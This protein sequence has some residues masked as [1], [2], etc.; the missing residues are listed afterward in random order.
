MGKMAKIEVYILLIGLILF[1]VGVVLGLDNILTISGI[2]IGG[3]IVSA[4]LGVIAK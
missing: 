3:A 2:L 4:I 1:T